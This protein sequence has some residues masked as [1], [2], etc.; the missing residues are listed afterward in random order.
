MSELITD[1]FNS[2]AFSVTSLTAAVNELPYVP[3]QAGKLGIFE[4]SGIPTTTFA[5]ERNKGVVSLIPNTPRGASANLVERNRRE[6]RNFTVPHLPTRVSIPADS[7]RNVRAFGSNQ[8]QSLEEVRNQHMMNH[9]NSLDATV[10]YQRVGALKG[11]IYDSDGSTLIY[12][13]FSEFSLTQDTTAFALTTSTTDVL[14]KCATVLRNMESALGGNGYT[15]AAAFVSN[16]FW[17]ALRSHA[18][19]QKFYINWMAASQ[20]ATSIN[21]ARFRGFIYG[22]IMWINYRGKVGTV[23]FIPDDKGYVFPVGA[24]GLFKTHFA[25]ADY[26]EAVGTNGLPRYAK[27]ELQDFGKGIDI[28]MQTNPLSYCT[29]PQTLQEVTIT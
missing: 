11:K 6:L 29:R 26:V 21:D 19:V 25:P 5:I 27:A 28:E 9:M 20:Y 4:E 18:N 13:L 1:I 17:D 3:G 8:L 2:D 16:T 10:E 23:S 7:L 22:D 15:F 24:P 12:D 14:G